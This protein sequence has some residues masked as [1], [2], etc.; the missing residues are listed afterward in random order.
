MV[1][2]ADAASAGEAGAEGAAPPG[3][4]FYGGDQGSRHAAAPARR[5]DV[6]PAEP[7]SDGAEIQD[8][9]LAQGGGARAQGAVQEHLHPADAQPRPAEAAAQA[10]GDGVVQ[11]L[12]VPVLRGDLGADEGSNGVLDDV[13]EA[14]I[15]LVAHGLFEFGLDAPE[16]IIEAAAH[17]AEHSFPAIAAF[18]GWLATAMVDFV[19]GL[20]PVISIEQKTLANNPRSTVA[21][22]TDIASYL[23]LLHATIGQ[24]RCP[25]TGEPA[26]R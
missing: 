6:E 5:F 1:A 20:S 21:T 2:A 18:A 16:Q 12:P 15:L 9:A 23:N 24:A 17:W 8:R 11:P 26:A 25:R 4:V 3:C 19:F 14:E 13:A 10:Q 7:G 22:M